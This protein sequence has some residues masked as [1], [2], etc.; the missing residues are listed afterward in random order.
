[1]ERTGKIQ[2]MP[3]DDGYV[4]LD[5]SLHEYFQQT[6]GSAGMRDAL[7]QSS[8]VSEGSV[9]SPLRGKS[10]NCVIRLYK[11]FYEDLNR[12]II[13]E[14][15][16]GT[17]LQ[18]DFEVTANFSTFFREWYLQFKDGDEFRRLLDMYINP[19]QVWINSPHGIIKFWF[20]CVEMNELLLNTIYVVRDGS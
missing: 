13:V 12:L 2:I 4:S 20:S 1:M 11:L 6:F 18:E 7:V 8:I 15:D 16:P 3:P 10:Y 14:H 9:G 19:K 5:H 17:N